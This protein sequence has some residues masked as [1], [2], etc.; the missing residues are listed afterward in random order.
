MKNA[1]TLPSKIEENWTRS[2]HTNRLRPLNKSRK[3]YSARKYPNQYNQH[4]QRQ[5]RSAPIHNH[6]QDAVPTDTMQIFVDD[7]EENM[8]QMS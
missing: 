7:V 8:Q 3:T 6:V 2:E 5:Q 1:T 4:N